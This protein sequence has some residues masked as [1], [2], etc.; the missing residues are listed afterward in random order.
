MFNFSSSLIHPAHI[1]PITIDGIPETI[2]QEV[3]RLYV[4]LELAGHSPEYW[5][6][7]PGLWGKRG[8]SSSVNAVPVE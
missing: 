4:A 7:R 2:Q 3:Q 8:Y 5:T 6:S 1:L